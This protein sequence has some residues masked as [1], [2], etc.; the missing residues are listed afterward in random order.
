MNFEN[1][2]VAID[3]GIG[4]V[5]INRPSK[6]NALNKATIQELHDAF[7]SLENDTKVRVI[8]VTGEGEKAFVA[9]A[10]ISEFAEFS[11]E[12]GAQL[13]AQGQELL[14]DFVEKLKTPVIESVNG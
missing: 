8:I 2:L 12:E 9:G 4:Q 5:T 3:N 1:I 11:V 7:E 13:A 6:L 14:F 10:D